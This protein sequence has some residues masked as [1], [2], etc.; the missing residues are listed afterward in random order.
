MSLDQLSQPEQIWSHFQSLRKFS[1]VHKHFSIQYKNVDYWCTAN[2]KFLFCCANIAIQLNYSW[3]HHLMLKQTCCL[4]MEMLDTKTLMYSGDS[5]ITGL[6]QYLAIPLEWQR[7]I[8]VWLQSHMVELSVNAKQ[9][10]LSL[11]AL[12]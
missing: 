12:L 9:V 2:I 1:T 10:L 3:E 11:C 4:R 5:P 6:S 7:G 8:T